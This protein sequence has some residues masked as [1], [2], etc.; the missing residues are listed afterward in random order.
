MK[1]LILTLA[2][3]LGLS[4]SAQAQ[5][6]DWWNPE[7]FVCRLVC[8]N[9]FICTPGTVVWQTFAFTD[10]QCISAAAPNAPAVFG[11]LTLTLSGRHI[12]NC[13]SYACF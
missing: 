7:N 1:K 6:D 8:Q 13:Q 2:L 4:V 10:Q 9:P 11:I 3:V 12:A 5:F